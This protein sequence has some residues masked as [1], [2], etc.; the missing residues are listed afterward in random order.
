VGTS[1]SYALPTGDFTTDFHVFA[2]EWDPWE[3]RWYVDDTLYRT[4]SSWFSEDAPY[5]APFDREFHLLVNVAV[6]GDFDGPPDATTVFPQT[7]EVDYVRVFKAVNVDPVVNLSEPVQGQNFA[8]GSLM[9]MTAV[10]TD[11]DGVVQ[12]VEFFQEDGLLGTARQEPYELEIPNLAAGCYSV[13]AVAH[14]DSGRRAFSN[15]VDM[16]VGDVCP[17]QS[18]FLMTPA[19]IPG[20][21][22][23][24]YYDIGGEDFAYNDFD[25]GNAGNAEI[26]V[27]ENVDI[28]RAGS[29]GGFAVVRTNRSEWLEFTVE[30]EEAG[31]YSASFW[32]GSAALSATIRLE[33][34]GI[35][36]TGDI[37][38]PNTGGE[39]HWSSLL[40]P[41]IP[42]E[43]GVQTM[44]LVLNSFGLGMDRITFRKSSSTGRESNRPVPGL[45]LGAY[46][47]PTRG[48]STVEY[49]IPVASLVE[50]AVFDLLGREVSTLDRGFRAAGTHTTTLDVGGLPRGVYLCRLTTDAGQ[51]SRPVT[52][53]H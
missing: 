5:P 7:M 2:L 28:S 24:E 51:V 9:R 41:D 40:V 25:A 37:A 45:R 16:T 53:Y 35:D 1:A 23:V 19:T 52:V 43:A 44:R 20:T 17:E 21:I 30:V 36:R 8:P 48:P 4:E 13:R 14:D 11:P 15:T 50:L 6:G 12:R 47:N 27:S 33:F 22:E 31:Q 49:S 42:L 10:A 18:P 39:T 32:L 29:S 3:L 46:P 26:R 34:D 38:V